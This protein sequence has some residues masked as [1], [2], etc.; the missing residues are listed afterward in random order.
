MGV[1]GTVE[2][3]ASACTGAAVGEVLS[4]NGAT[5]QRDR[6]S[7]ESAVDSWLG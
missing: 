1:M 2:S 7:A 6:A 5:A 3:V 4:M